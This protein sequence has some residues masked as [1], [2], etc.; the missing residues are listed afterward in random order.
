MVRPTR[1]VRKLNFLDHDSSESSEIDDS[2]EDPDYIDEVE[3]EIIRN[4]TKK[5]SVA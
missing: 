5:V 1:L 4:N 2:D 3:A